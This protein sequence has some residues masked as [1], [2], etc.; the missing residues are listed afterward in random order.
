[1]EN[2]NLLHVAPHGTATPAP[3]DPGSLSRR[4]AGALRISDE[5]YEEMQQAL[6]EGR[7][8]LRLLPCGKV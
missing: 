5:R 1:M 2:L 8:E 6:R 3:K 7:D 4:F